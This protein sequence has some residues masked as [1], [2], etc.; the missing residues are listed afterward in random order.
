MAHQREA[1]LD[2]LVSLKDFVDQFETPTKRHEKAKQKYSKTLQGFIDSAN[3]QL[4]K[5]YEAKNNK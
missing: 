5:Y 4:E 2:V 3:R 1:D